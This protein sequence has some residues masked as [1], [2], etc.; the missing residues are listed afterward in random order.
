MEVSYGFEMTTVEDIFNERERAVYNRMIADSLDYTLSTK[1]R[2][3][4]RSLAAKKLKKAISRGRK[5]ECVSAADMSVSNLEIVFNE[6][7]RADYNRMITGSLDMT[8]SAAKRRSNRSNAAAKLKIA[9][10]TRRVVNGDQ[11][12]IH[13][14]DK[15]RKS[16]S[17]CQKKAWAILKEKAST[18]N[19]DAIVKLDARR[20]GFAAVRTASKTK[21]VDENAASYAACDS[22][23]YTQF[24]LGCASHAQG[25]RSEASP[26]EPQFSKR[27][28]SLFLNGTATV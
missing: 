23:G 1:K 24:G 14:L 20:A 22:F 11:D 5:E 26:L 13:A 28:T 2:K 3:A 21:W 18:G 27:L 17:D 19:L 25:F 10:L 9:I 4:N 12:A 8:L 15:I 16:D 6:K 7:Q